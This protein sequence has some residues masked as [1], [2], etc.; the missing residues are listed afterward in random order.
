M[1]TPTRKFAPQ[2]PKASIDPLVPWGWPLLGLLFEAQ[3]LQMHALI[4]W[5]ESIAI[6]I[7]DLRDQCAVRY[8]GGVPIDS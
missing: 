4:V 6:F 2:Q 8:C 5:Q 3:Q 7:K 1:A